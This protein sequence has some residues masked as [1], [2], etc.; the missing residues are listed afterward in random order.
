[1]LGAHKQGWDVY[2]PASVTSDRSLFFSSGGFWGKWEWHQWRIPNSLV[3]RKSIFL[4]RDSF[5]RNIKHW[6]WGSL[7]V[8]NII[9]KL[10][11]CLG[12]CFQL[13]LDASG[14]RPTEIY[15]TGFHLDLGRRAIFKGMTK[16]I[17]E[18]KDFSDMQILSQK[19]EM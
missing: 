9:Y 6:L 15:R 11:P 17:P 19:W 12:I 2:V 5:Q 16:P 1:M 10:L 8:D 3:T 14:V 4:T 18:H 7:A 13:P